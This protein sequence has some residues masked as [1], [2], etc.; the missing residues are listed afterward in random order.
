MSESTVS[1]ETH[2]FESEVDDLLHLVV[3]SLYSNSEIFLRELVSNASDALDK[4]KFMA[5]SDADLYEGDMDLHIHVQHDPKARTITISDNGI[6]MSRDE[7]VQNLG[8]IARSGTKHFLK[9]LTADKAKNAEFIGQFGVGFYSSFIVADK[10]TVQSRRAGLAPT[11]A[12]Q[13]SSEGKGGYELE[14]IEKAARG[15]T[16]TLHLKSDQEEFLN[17]MRLK[18][19][20][21]KYS[22]HIAYPIRMPVPVSEVNPDD[23][24]SETTQESG[25]EVVNRATALWTLPKSDI[26]EE[27]YQELYKHISHDFDNALAW[28]HNKVEGKLEYTSLLY[29]PK[30]PPFDIWNPERARGLKLYV[31]RVFIMDEAEQFLPRYLRFIRGVVDSADLP[32]NISREI[33]QSNR[34][35]DS[36]RSGITKRVLDMLSSMAKDKPDDYQT[37]W[38][39]FGQI[40]KEGPAEDMANRE[41]VLSLLR[42]SS[43]HLDTSEASVAL[44][45]YLERMK[46]GQDQI[47][48]LSAESFNAAKHSPHLEAFRRRGVEVLLLHDKID[49]WMMSHL[50]EYKGKAFKSVAQG[51]MVDLSFA[52][53]SEE[54]TVDLDAENQNYADTLSRLKSLYGERVKDVRLSTRLTESPAC[55]VADD[56]GMTRQ[57]QRLMAS[58]GHQA[59]FQPVLELNPEH[60]LMKRLRASIDT[61]QF[62][63][64]ALLILDSA[65]LAEGAQLDDP[66]AFVKRFNELLLKLL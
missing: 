37:F 22:D 47:Y 27:S 53:A 25:E 21:G 38:K 45:A 18:H 14:S 7:I 2:R 59:D 1:A 5:M 39:A 36:M 62:E 24:E 17:N 42:F 6:G 12:I 48:Y 65:T 43:T 26:S 32:L 61:P 8:T 57:M 9:E 63:D 50:S 28:A 41:T 44:D 19:V 3:H 15:T 52:E 11:D 20:I 4:L 66:G 56:S 55:I 51:S 46:E 31:R 23:A 30:N 54:D 33:L 34:A 10:V 35:V 16:I 13:W 40:L 58:A 29:L 60:D 64:M 49:E